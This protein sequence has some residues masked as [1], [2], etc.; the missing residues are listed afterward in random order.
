MRRWPD[1]DHVFLVKAPAFLP[2]WLVHP[3][4]AAFGRCGRNA[5]TWEEWS[6]SA[7]VG[8]CATAVPMADLERDGLGLPPQIAPFSGIGR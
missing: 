7:S 1:S 2:G 8:R 6:P 4:V 3:S 5:V